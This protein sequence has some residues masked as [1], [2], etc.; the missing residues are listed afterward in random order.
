MEAGRALEGVS[1]RT[2]FVANAIVST[3]ALGFLAYVL[4]L[5]E[6]APAGTVDLRFLPAV[7]A[8]LNA[9]AALLLAA[10]WVAIR[11]RAIR[12]H[13]TL[14]IAAFTASAL[15]LACYLVYH[16]AH[17]DT[18]YQ[19]EGLLRAIYFFI[20][21]THILLSIFVVPAAL[22]AFYFAWKRQFVR[23]RRLT[24]IAL[25]IWLYVSVTGVLIYFMLRSSA[26]ALP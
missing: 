26:A 11:R 20:L 13:R 10:G 24:R 4:L 6:T 7:N 5:R 16:W 17:G 19:G 21:I 18:R 3:A 8:S 22:T 25:P 1:D 23:H 2:F 14:M 9:V 12:L 15:F